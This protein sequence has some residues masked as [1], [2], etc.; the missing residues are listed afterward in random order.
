MRKNIN[1]IKPSKLIK[2][3]S[4]H[5]SNNK[6]SINSSADKTPKYISISYTKEKGQIYIILELNYDGKIKYHH[7]VF[8]LLCTTLKSPLILKD[9]LVRIFTL[10]KIHFNVNEVKFNFK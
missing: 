8:D 4:K 6:D 7:G 10:L 1:S 5:I 3:N 2:P 9:E